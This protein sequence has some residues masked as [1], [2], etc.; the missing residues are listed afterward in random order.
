MPDCGD[1]PWLSAIGSLKR[2]G[3]RGGSAAPWKRPSFHSR[4]T[5][6]IRGGVRPPR[7]PWSSP[8]AGASII[9]RAIHTITLEIPAG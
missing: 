9:S 2:P 5:L 6:L 7:R 4:S 3:L 1:R 8:I